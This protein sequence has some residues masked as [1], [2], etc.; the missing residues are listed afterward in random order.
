MTPIPPGA[1][2][3][4]RTLSIVIP[5]LDEAPSIAA[6]VADAGAHADEVVVVDGGSRDRTAALAADAGAVVV[7]APRGRASQMNAGAAR[8]RGDALLFLHADVRLPPGAGS[9]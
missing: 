5:A 9:A 8:A 4:P 6:A 7:V 2:T 1:R 3:P